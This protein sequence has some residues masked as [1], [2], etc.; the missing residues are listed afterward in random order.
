MSSTRPTS[1]IAGTGHYAPEKVL[2]NHDLERMVDT[3]D[4]WIVE[5]TGIRERHIAAEG[6]A[7]SDMAAH[8]ARAAHRR[9]P[10]SRPT[11]LDLIIVATVTPDMPLPSTAVF[12]QQKIGARPRL[13]GVRHRGRLRRLHL[14]D[15]HRRPL[16]RHGAAHATCW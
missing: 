15:V 11:D 16:H 1:R 2:T 9:R 6:E 12:V 7:T 5:R 10:A 3:S 4:E 13:S 8:A 14:R